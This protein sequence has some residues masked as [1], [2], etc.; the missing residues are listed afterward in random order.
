VADTTVQLV[1]VITSPQRTEFLKGQ[2]AEFEKA[3]PG[4][5]VE[6]VS[7]PWSQA[8]EKFLSMV[9]AGQTPD[10]VEMPERW[11]GLYANNGQLEDLGPYM[12]TW[13]EYATLGDRAKQFG[14]TVKNTQYMIPYG[15]Y[16]NA[17]FWNKKLFKEAGLTGPPQTMDEFEADAKKI[18]ELGN[19]K[20]GYCLRGGAGAFGSIQQFMNNMDGKAGYFNADGTSTFNEEGS[21]KGLQMLADIYQKG[22]APKDAVSWGFNELV[23]GFYTGTCALLNQDPDALIGIAEK[24]SP[25]DFA[26]APWPVG[27]SGKAF[28]ALGYAGWAM[29]SASKSKPEAWKVMSFLLDNKQNLGWAKTVGVL[30]IHK[31]AEQNE[32]FRTEQFSGWFE[33]LNDPEKY[34]FV[35][36]PTYLEN[37]G[38]FYDSLVPAAFQQLL[39]GKKSAKDVADEWAKFLNDEQQKYM[40]AHK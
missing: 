14:S 2:L 30:P 37:L 9:Q 1:E 39:L 34:V 13:A 18:S 35:T 5:K 7:L 19:G 38:V 4:I 32:Y 33:E 17:M 23:T 11:M 29:M 6:V 15:Y 24:M 40:A 36:P 25:N 31:G 3:N 21:V 8:F 12:K 27:P 26:V 20:Y 16:V 10:I 28:P 22:W